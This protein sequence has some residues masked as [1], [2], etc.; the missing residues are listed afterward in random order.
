[1]GSAFT[2]SANLLGIRSPVELRAL[3]CHLLARD[4]RRR[5][6][7]RRRPDA[8]RHLPQAVD[9]I[10][11]VELRRVPEDPTRCAGSPRCAA[12]FVLDPDGVTR[13]KLLG[14]ELGTFAE[15]APTHRAPAEAATRA[16]QLSTGVG[17]P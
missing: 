10:V 16:G 9:A 4:Y 3:V 7:L 1:M 15:R 17:G 6:R 13:I 14:T 5:D 12:A 8:G 2:P 11:E